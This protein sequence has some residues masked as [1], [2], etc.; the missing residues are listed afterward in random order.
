M[1]L[2]QQ[3]LKYLDFFFVLAYNVHMD[4]TNPLLIPPELQDPPLP[5]IIGGDTAE[6]R[7]NTCRD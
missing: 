1:K 3:H 6:P 7:K 5:R 4:D 2:A